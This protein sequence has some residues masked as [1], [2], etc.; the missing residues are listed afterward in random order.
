MSSAV[1]SEE[2]K[3]CFIAA[4]PPGKFPVSIYGSAEQY[5]ECQQRCSV[6]ERAAITEELDTIYEHIK[7]IEADDEGFKDDVTMMG[8]K[9]P[10]VEVAWWAVKSWYDVLL[11]D[12]NG[13]T[14]DC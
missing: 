10:A 1:N 9:I 8:E 3:R 5:A 11:I 12:R 13:I 14:D 2:M 7:R 4:W 6:E